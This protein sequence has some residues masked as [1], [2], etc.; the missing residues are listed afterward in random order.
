M[1][2]SESIEFAFILQS[3]WRQNHLWLR[4]QGNVIKIYGENRGG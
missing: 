1:E 2:R 4:G 3:L